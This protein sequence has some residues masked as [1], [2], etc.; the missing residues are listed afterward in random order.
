M[1]LYNV[2]KGS[3]ISSS[4]K[5][6]DS[7][8]KRLMGLMGKNGLGKEECLIIKPCS[9][10]HTFCMK[11]SIDVVFM[12]REGKVVKLIRGITP[13]KMVMPIKEAYFV[14]EF[15]SRNEMTFEIEEGD[16]LK[17]EEI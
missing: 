12:D 17:I 11:F 10:I 15:D 2:S 9:S 13:K 7:F 4:V 1:K 8:F 6:A 16:V 14:V 5:M 3:E